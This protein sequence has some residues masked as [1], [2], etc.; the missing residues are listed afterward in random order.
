MN[1]I[2]YDF[3]SQYDEILRG[4][5]DVLI[6]ADG[7]CAPCKGCFRCW[8][9]HPAECFIKDKLRRVCR[10]VGG[11]DVLTVASENLYGSYS[12]NIKTV[13]DRSIGL[14]TPLSVYRGKQMRHALRYGKHSLLRAI[15][16][17]D[18]TEREKDTFL[19]IAKRNA[20][21]Y[22]YEKSEVVFLEN[23]SNLED[24]L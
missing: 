18:I 2:I 15:V 8:T 17:G 19:T 5:Y 12:P 24:V 13:L 6:H 21:N 1:V 3:G 14:S 23:P 16:Y 20:L 11:A 7:N 4:K 10:D 22:G 9:K